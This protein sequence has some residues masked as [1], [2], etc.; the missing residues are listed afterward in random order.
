MADC[1][2]YYWGSFQNPDGSTF[3]RAI[4]VTVACE[5]QDWVR[6]DAPFM[7]DQQFYL[8]GDICNGGLAASYNPTWLLDV[9]IPPVNQ[10]GQ[11]FSA[12]WNAQRTWVAIDR[13]V[14]SSCAGSWHPFQQEGV[15]AP[16][17][18]GWLGVFTWIAGRGFVR[19]S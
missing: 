18:T 8:L 6:R 2:D 1:I 14:R 13:D 5:F 15:A 19:T 7:I 9:G 16:R 12:R 4:G 11:V 10:E 17:G 3:W